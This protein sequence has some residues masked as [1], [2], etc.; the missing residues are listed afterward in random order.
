VSYKR[1]FIAEL[2]DDIQVSPCGNCA[3]KHLGT[4]TCA[5]F[6]SY[7]PAKII[8]GKND[9]TEPF[10]GDNGIRFEAIQ[11]VADDA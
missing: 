10:P 1:R 3:H 5:A 2:D 11:D 8:D 7:I 9:H 6:A 4:R